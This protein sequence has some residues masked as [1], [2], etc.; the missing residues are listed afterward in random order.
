MD[1][2][3]KPASMLLISLDS[4]HTLSESGIMK[5][6]YRTGWDFKVPY[7]I[8]PFPTAKDEYSYGKLVI[9]YPKA[10]PTTTTKGET[11]LQFCAVPTQINSN[12]SGIGLLGI[13]L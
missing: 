1:I 4:S 5:F 2:Q 8:H 6:I 11:S 12:K 3:Y 13:P 7:I 10:K 9:P